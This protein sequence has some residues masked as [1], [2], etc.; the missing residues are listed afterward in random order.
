LFIDLT[1]AY[2]SVPLSKLWETLDKSTINARL[3]V[4]IK[5]LYNGSNSKIKIGHQ[6]T[7]GFKM[8]KGL[9]QGCSL[10]PT[11]FKIYLEQVLRN[12]KRKCQ[13]MGIP[14]QN[15]YVYSLNFAD[16]QLLLAQDH[17]DME[18]MARKLKEEYEEWGLTIN[19]EKTEYVC[20]GEEKEA[21]KFD[22]GEEINPCI[23]CTYLGTK[24]DQS[25]DNATEIKH[26]IGQTRKAINALNSIWWHKNITKNRKL[27]IYQSI[28]QSI[29]TYGAEVWQIPTREMNKI[30]SI[31]MDVLRRA[32]RKSRME[33]I[34]NEHIK[35]IM[36][37]K[38]K[39]NII[40]V[41]EMKRLQWYG[42]VKR[43]LEERIPKLIMEWIP[44]RE[45]EKRV[46]KE[47]L[48]RRSASSHD[49][50]KCGARSVEKQGGMAFGFRK[51]ATAV[52]IPDR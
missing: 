23:E 37:V 46:P 18:Y 14:I 3:M 41:I 43:T 19:L 24:I 33:R 42:H 27:Y 12:W 40:E 6:I 35:G 31:E 45:K 51:T 26:G 29:L 13:P 22:C 8:T 34:K 16:D 7:K 1:K 32:A 21:L 20:I 44:L 28:I 10:S 11:L 49:S 50:R 52:M 15:T 4:A 9:G 38:G 25:G 39:L 5:S 36:G 30:I 47:D 17:D 2:D 48:D